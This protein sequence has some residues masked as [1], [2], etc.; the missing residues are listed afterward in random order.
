MESGRWGQSHSERPAI[1]PLYRPVEVIPMVEQA[2]PQFRRADD[3]QTS[4]RHARLDEAQEIER[5]VQ[6]A[7]SRV[8]GDHDRLSAA[9][10]QGPEHEPFV[11]RA[12]QV[13]G[14]REPR[15]EARSR[16]RA[17]DEGAVTEDAVRARD[18]AA[19]EP[20]ETDAQ[21]VTGGAQGGGVALHDQLGQRRAVLR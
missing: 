11:A 14:E 5:A 20:R 1:A 21:L 9:Y 8:A 7:Y 6:H 4:E 16:R 15:D 17:R 12:P 18:G 2:Q 3:G 13:V 10:P 19:Q